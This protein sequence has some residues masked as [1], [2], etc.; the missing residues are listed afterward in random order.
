MNDRKADKSLI[1]QVKAVSVDRTVV[2]PKSGMYYMDQ[3]NTI[4]SAMAGLP[5]AVVVLADTKPLAR[6]IVAAM[7]EKNISVADMLRTKFME[8]VREGKLL[9]LTDDGP[10][11]A[12]L[13]LTI[14]R[15]GLTFQPFRLELQPVVSAR[16]ELIRSDG[17]ILW[18]K[19]RTMSN[20]SDKDEVPAYRFAAYRENAELL[21]TGFETAC[22]IVVRDLVQDLRSQ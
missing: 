20:H 18:S 8:E 15:Y 2:M 21:R 3:T 9:N 1:A 17:V 22:N 16:A 7:A 19:T 6:Q 13:K 4:A 14:L 10:A 12:K 11:D 5:G